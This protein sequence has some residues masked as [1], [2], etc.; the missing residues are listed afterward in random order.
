MKGTLPEKIRTRKDKIGFDTPQADWFRKSIFQKYILDILH[1]DSFRSRN[2]II[3]E[4]RSSRSARMRAAVWGGVF[5][6]SGKC[7]RSQPYVRVL[8]YGAAR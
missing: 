8:Q 6:I 3:P 4:K 2:L 5:P 7:A 1:S